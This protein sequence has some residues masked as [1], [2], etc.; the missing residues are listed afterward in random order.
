[1]HDVEDRCINKYGP[2]VVLCEGERVYV[3]A[4]T[5]LIYAMKHRNRINYVRHTGMKQSAK[6]NMYYD[7][8][9]A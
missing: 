5:S 1:M 6:G 8:G 7:F 2:T 9:L 4:P 3:W